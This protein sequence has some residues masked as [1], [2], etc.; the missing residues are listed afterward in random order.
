MRGEHGE[1]TINL[2]QGIMRGKNQFHD[3]L[4]ARGALAELNKRFERTNDKKKKKET[5]NGY[6][7]N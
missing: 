3:G 2:P 1:E 5:E 4:G 6:R 7:T